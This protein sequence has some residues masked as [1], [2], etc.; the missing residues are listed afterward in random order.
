MFLGNICLVNILL[1]THF[2]FSSE[3]RLWYDLQITLEGR[4]GKAAFLVLGTTMKELDLSTSID[5]LSP[6]GTIFSFSQ[7]TTKAYDL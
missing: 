7:S 3:C 5:I 2:I 4:L 1:L 6:H